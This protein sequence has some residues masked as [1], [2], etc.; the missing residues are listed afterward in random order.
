[1]TQLIYHMCPFEAWATALTAGA[2]SG[3]A[4][5]LADG[6]IHFSTAGQAAETARRH[7]RGQD[8]LVF[9]TVRAEAL[10]TVEH[11]AGEPAG[12]GRKSGA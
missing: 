11:Q 2:Y 10:G 12:P 3:T 1:M 5:D 9:L 6:F 7:F 4:Q 8:G